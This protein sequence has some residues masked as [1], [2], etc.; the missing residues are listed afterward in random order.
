MTAE[1]I[2]DALGLPASSRVDQRVAKKLVTENAS[3]TATDKRRIQEGI[4]E[5]V[6][7]AALKPTNIGVPAFRDNVRE[8]LEIAVLSVTLRAQAK[9]PR[10]EEL[11]HRAI[12]YPVLLTATQC[13]TVT[14]SLAH[15]RW[16]HGEAGKVVLEGVHSVAPF[17]SDAPASV[18]TS[19][20]GSVA[21]PSRPSRD[22]FALYQGWLDRVL[23]LEAAQITGSFVV[24]GSAEQASLLRG[25]LDS[26][27][28][29]R[30]DIAALRAE[31]AKE[32]QVSRLVE[33]NLEIKQL[34]QELRHVA[35]QL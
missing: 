31:A 34:E 12:P 32:K 3:P 11:I 13:G 29:L 20:L 1:R 9:R 30:Q 6:W 21:I 19:F 2:I 5:L 16:S 15:K 14:L 35:S 28:R 22:L 23:A 26:H 33:L 7:V 24:P 4:E 10:L 8:Y 27:A 18:V 25:N 17:E